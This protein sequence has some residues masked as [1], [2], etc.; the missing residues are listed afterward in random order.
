[1]E[2]HPTRRE[3]VNGIT[4][5]RLPPDW[6]DRTGPGFV[7]PSTVAYLDTPAE[8]PN[9]PRPAAVY[10]SGREKPEEEAPNPVP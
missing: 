8:L 2:Q 9:I 4:R 5:Y 7:P 3:T 6:G 10:H 1:M